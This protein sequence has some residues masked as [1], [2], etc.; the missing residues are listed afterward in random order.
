MTPRW[1]FS[2]AG[3][4]G[5]ALPAGAAADLPEV[6]DRAAGSVVGIEVTPA[7]VRPAALH[8]FGVG[9]VFDPNGHVVTTMATVGGAEAVQVRLDDG[10]RVDARVVGT[11]PVFGIAVLE[12]GTRAP[13]FPLGRADLARLGEPV[14][15]VTRAADG[16]VVVRAGILSA[17]GGAGGASPVLDD[18][19]HVDFD[20]DP[21]FAGA[22]LLDAAGRVLGLCTGRATPPPGPARRR[23]AAGIRMVLGT[24]LT[25]IPVDAISEAVRQIVERG[26]VDWPWL[27][28]VVQ[29]APVSG[30]AARVEVA[31]LPPGSPAATGGVAPGDLVVSIDGRRVRRIA[32]V[33]RAVLARRIG[34]HVA[35]I[36]ERGGRSQTLDLVVQARPGP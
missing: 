23:G 32:D 33:Q 35:L 31:T 21:S 8:R 2:L 27:G 24:R 22:P 36:V 9:F 1:V 12:V 14:A 4:A 18:D 3:L 26:H 17:R 30:G 25:A 6:V 34:Q 15:A 7:D 20:L 19:L 11:D 29:E 16:R 10:R 28:L 5:L 13:A